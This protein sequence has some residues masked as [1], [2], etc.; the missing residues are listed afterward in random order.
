M[1]LFDLVWDALTNV[2]TR[3]LVPGSLL[4]GIHVPGHRHLAARVAH[5]TLMGLSRVPVAQQLMHE[6]H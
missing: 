2:P 6:D 1:C 3:S 5:G 4:M